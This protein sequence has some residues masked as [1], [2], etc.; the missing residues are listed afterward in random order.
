MIKIDNQD[1]LICLRAGEAADAHHGAALP[2]ISQASL[3]RKRTM[4][5]LLDGLSREHAAH[6]YSRG[7]NP[8]VKVLEETLAKLERGVAC[9]CF[10]SGMG[11][12]SA[13]LFGLLKSGD[14]VLFVND[15]YGPT[16]ELAARLEDFGVTWSQT[17]ARDV[18][19]IAA[20][21]RTETRLLYMES[22][23]SMLFRL[24]PVAE[25]CA[26]AKQH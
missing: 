6:I 24:A 13:V 4:K 14:H 5:E 1:R 22:P 17:F 16:L 8:T 11:A 10:G 20:E 15:I 19:S 7:T 18:N 23:G 26:M 3:F 21:M 25:L 12:I 9:K 2:S